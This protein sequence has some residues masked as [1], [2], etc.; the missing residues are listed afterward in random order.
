MKPGVGFALRGFKLNRLVA[1][2]RLD[3]FLET[4]I[5]AS[6]EDG[7]KLYKMILAVVAAQR[8]LSISG[9]LLKG[10][11]SAI[12]GWKLLLP[13]HPCVGASSKL[14]WLVLWFKG[15]LKPVHIEG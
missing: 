9:S 15:L 13:S 10:T 4:V 3:R 12:K 5:Q 11:V 7:T 2:A 8:K 14:W 6:F 1:P